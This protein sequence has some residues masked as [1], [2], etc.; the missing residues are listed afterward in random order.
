MLCWY[1][2]G[3]VVGVGGVGYW[4]GEVGCGVGCVVGW[5]W[6]WFVGDYVEFC[7]WFDFVC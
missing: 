3:G 6:F 1:C 5:D 4:Y 2:G 7:V